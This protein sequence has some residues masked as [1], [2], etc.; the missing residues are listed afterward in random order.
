M[1]SPDV[2]VCVPAY[3]AHA[4]PNVATVAETLEA[5]LGGLSGELI[6]A[7]NGVEAG[8]VGVPADVRV[9]DLGVNRGVS[10]GW[11]AAAA[12]AAGRVLAFCNDDVAL[13]RDSLRLLH[14]TLVERPEAGVVGP[15]GTLW[16]LTVPK[17]LEWLD[18]SARRPGE[19]ERCDVVA[20][21]LF[22]MR[23]ETWEAL[24]GFDEA[25]APCSMEDVDLCTDVRERLGLEC[26]A[27]AGVETEHEYGISVTRPWKRISHNGRREFLRTIHVRNV[28]HFK[29]K[30]GKL[31]GD[32]S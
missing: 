8:A 3:K 30:W 29:A 2:S 16:D 9:V 21:F 10:P 31:V 17:H 13:G 12:V 11:N 20:G 4:E 6:V 24:G 27:V 32:A 15:D 28:R 19:I 1:P 26:Y 25:Y 22:A 23:R 7:L 14:D 5:A 18:L